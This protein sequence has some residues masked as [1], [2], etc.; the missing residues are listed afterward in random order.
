[1]NCAKDM[2]LFSIEFLGLWEQINPGLKR[3]E[4]DTPARLK[5]VFQSN[6]AHQSHLS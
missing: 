3:V 6:Q 5:C 4:F 2:A 1:M